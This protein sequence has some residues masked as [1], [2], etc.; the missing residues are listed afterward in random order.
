MHSSSQTGLRKFPSGQVVVPVN[1]S[2][3]REKHEDS[4][5]RGTCGLHGSTSFVSATLQSSLA[6]RL[7]TA[8]VS[9][10]S[11]LY[12]LTWKVRTTKLGRQICALRALAHRMSD[13]GYSSWPSPVT[14][15]ATGSTHCY[16]SGDHSKIAL[17]LPGAARLAGWAT[18]A[19][20]AE[21]GGTPEQFLNRKRRALANGKRL[22]VSLT[23][24][25]LQAL[26]SGQMP[27]GSR[28]QTANIG[29][30]NPEHSRW[31]MGYPPEWGNCAPMVMPSSRKS[32]QRL[33][34]RQ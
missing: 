31:L 30:L 15:D 3:K 8:L 22:G 33:S 12:L 6:N 9:T 14:N 17:K 7:Q 32:R 4:Q 16:I 5:T 10:G 27:N 20:A 21:A 1:R 26:L 23:S 29:Q 24:L 25:S 2:R 28:L 19:A 11:T 13:K 34:R 18:A